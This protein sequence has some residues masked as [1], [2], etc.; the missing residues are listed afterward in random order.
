MS[1]WARHSNWS[2]VPV[3]SY[4]SYCSLSLVTLTTSPFLSSFPV[5]VSCVWPVK[6]EKSP[7][8]TP[9]TLPTPRFDLVSAPCSAWHIPVHLWTFAPFRLSHN[10]NFVKSSLFLFSWQ[11]ILFCSQ[12]LSNARHIMWIN[13]PHP[14]RDNKSLS[15]TCRGS[16]VRSSTE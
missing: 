5:V 14:Q 8:Q 10:E 1:L 13:L 2:P 15:L 3:L 9:P 4:D 12:G 16:S 6:V 11:M 7:S